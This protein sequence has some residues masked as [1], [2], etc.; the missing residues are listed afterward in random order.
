MEVKA[1]GKRTKTVQ[2]C[3]WSM[4]G[5]VTKYD[6][7]LTESQDVTGVMQ[8]DLQIFFFSFK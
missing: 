5:N 1:G 7:W 2:W 3:L 4:A 8:S 6:I